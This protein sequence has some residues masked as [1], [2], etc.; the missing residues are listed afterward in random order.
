[1]NA[2]YEMSVEPICGDANSDWQVDVGDVV[3]IVSYVF[4]GGQAPSPAC[5]ADANGDGD[6]NVGDAVHLVGYIF[7]GGAAPAPGCCR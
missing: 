2:T 5:V 1:L 7:K 3:F 6:I 4:K